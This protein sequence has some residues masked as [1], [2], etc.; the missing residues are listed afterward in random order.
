MSILPLSLAAS[1]VNTKI[2]TDLLDECWHCSNVVILSVIV[3]ISVWN[4]SILSYMTL[5]SAWT[6][7]ETSSLSLL[8]KSSSTIASTG[9]AVE[10][11]GGT[12]GV[13]AT[14]ARARGGVEGEQSLNKCGWPPS[15]N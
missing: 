9:G 7:D 14:Q 15:L 3:C 13:D 10:L 1:L 5:I 8:K 6:M 12:D 2:S 4:P 11:I